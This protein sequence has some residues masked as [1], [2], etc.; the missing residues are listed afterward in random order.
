MCATEKPSTSATWKH[1]EKTIALQCRRQR[2]RLGNGGVS[3]V[4]HDDPPPLRHAVACGSAVSMSKRRRKTDLNGE[5]CWTTGPEYFSFY[6]R[7]VRSLRRRVIFDS[8]VPDPLSFGAIVC[9][10]KRRSTPAAMSASTSSTRA[11]SSATCCSDLGGRPR[12]LLPRSASCRSRLRFPQIG[13]ELLPRN[14]AS[15]CVSDG[16]QPRRRRC[17]ASVLDKGAP[18]RIG[19]HAIEILSKSPHVR[20][21]EKIRHSVLN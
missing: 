17:F 19:V 9:S 10:A 3:A 15:Q 5:Y 20:T 16:L 21:G 12:T 11:S 14:S 13:P 2:D 4:G 1:V 8:N 18:L 6:L 7:S